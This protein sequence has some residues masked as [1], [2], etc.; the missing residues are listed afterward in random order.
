MNQSIASFSYE[1]AELSESAS[2]T[3]GAAVLPESVLSS[4]AFDM[5]RFSFIEPRVISGTKTSEA[6][7]VLY[8]RI[9]WTSVAG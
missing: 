6:A 8:Q 7:T 2:S 9:I 5:E 4:Y 1:A 3:T